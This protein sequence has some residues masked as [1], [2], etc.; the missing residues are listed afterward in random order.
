[1]GDYI[2]L[3]CERLNPGLWAEPLNAV[4]NASFFVAA[5]FAFL[6]HARQNQ[7]D[8]GAL[9]LIALLLAI[10]TG[11]TLFH[12]FA[13]HLTMMSD[14]LPILFYQITFI[15]LYTRH[16]M[17]LSAMRYAGLLCVFI[18]MT[19]ASEFAPR[20]ILNGSLGYAPAIIFLCG[21]GFWHVKNKMRE[22]LVLLG[23]AFVF[24][25][26]LTL[27]SIDMAVCDSVPFGTH[28]MWHLLNGCVLYLTTRA[29]ILNIRNEITE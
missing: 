12:T 4:T 28:F 15:I 3:Y 6:L 8:G 27:R 17:C 25:L 1:M 11:S 13:T 26:S 29:Y 7:R 5:F 10:G 19:V 9:I 14:V 2:D 22:P 24:A 16:V 21:F 18:A 23:A 20:H